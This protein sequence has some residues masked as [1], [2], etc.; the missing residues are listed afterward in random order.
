VANIDLKQLLEQARAV[1]PTAQQWFVDV[2]AP[3]DDPFSRTPT[4]EIQTAG[5]AVAVPQPAPLKPSPWIEALY[6]D[7]SASLRKGYD[8]LDQVAD[9]QIRGKYEKRIVQL[10]WQIRLLEYVV[11]ELTPCPPTTCPNRVGGDRGLS[12]ADRDR[13]LRDMRQAHTA[14][15]MAIKVQTPAG[16]QYRIVPWKSGGA[17]ELDP[18]DMAA[19]ART[20]ALAGIDELTLLDRLEVSTP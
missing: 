18:L 9:E 14:G 11:R 7:L 15:H 6:N 5:P 19:L 2:P 10:A 20:G 12:P 16:R 13:L 4:T 3:A 8:L 17:G 1:S